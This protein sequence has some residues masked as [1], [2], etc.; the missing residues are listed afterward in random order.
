M[1]RIILA[2]ASPRR[3]EI[4]EQVE[5]SFTVVPSQ[6]EENISE[7][8][9]E[10]YVCCLSRQKA[11]EV[12]KQING[13]VSLDESEETERP[14]ENSESVVVIGADT[15]VVHRGHIL[16]KPK[17][18]E[19]AF[20]MISELAGDTHAVYTGVTLMVR[21]AGGGILQKTFAEKTEVVVEPMRKEQIWKYI[22]SGEPMDKA[23]AYAIQGKFA[24]YIKEI[25]GD[26]YNVVGFPL[27]RVV[28]EAGEMGIF[29]LGE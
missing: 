19:D 27:A 6:M 10:A 26:Y 8:E 21:Q 4:L 15:V 1:N 12:M 20:R 23:G 9:P 17:S 24:P 13:D 5:I 2:S 29:L 16:E 7:T 18:R 3:R 22:D 28:K 11:T 14:E 25:H